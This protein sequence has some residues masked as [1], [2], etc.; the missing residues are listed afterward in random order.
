MS[1]YHTMAL[2]SIGNAR[3]WDWKRARPPDDASVRL[4]ADPASEF[5]TQERAAAARRR[6]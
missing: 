2:V 3:C 6:D 4:A 1:R 5:R